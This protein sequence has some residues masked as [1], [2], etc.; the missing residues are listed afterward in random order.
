MGG[1]PMEWTSSI[2]RRKKDLPV[3]NLKNKIRKCDMDVDTLSKGMNI[4]TGVK[5]PKNS[6]LMASFVL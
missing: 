1:L 5:G 6:T 3:S 2:K 4:P